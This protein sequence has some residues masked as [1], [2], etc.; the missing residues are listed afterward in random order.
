MGP[1]PTTMRKVRIFVAS[2][3]DVRDERDQLGR[4]VSELNQI[5]AALVPEA[6]LVLELVRW[7]THVHPGLGTDAQDVVNQQLDIGEYDVF[8][9]IFWLRFG[10]PTSRAESGTEEEFGIAYRAWKELG[11]A[12]QIMV[13][14]CRALAPPAEDSDAV[15]QLHKVV[16]FRKKLFDEGL[17]RDY[18]EHAEFADNVRRDLVLVLGQMLHATS[19]PAGI[20]DQA[21]QAVTDDDRGATRERIRA[22]AYEY[23]A[24]RDPK[25]GM[26][27]G[28][29]RTRRMEIV[30]SK[31]RA[32]ALSVYPFVDE[33][34]TSRSAGERLAAVST[35]EAVPD[36]RYLGWLAERFGP[37]KPFVA[38][39][40]ALGLLSAA[41]SLDR[42][43][44]PQVRA[45]LDEAQR[46]T[47]GLRE[48]T[49]RSTTLRYADHELV[50]RLT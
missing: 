11:R 6:G 18:G 36:A 23:D 28:S 41:R 46:A 17:A 50:R 42:D 7:E 37:E 9:G 38:Y 40:A 31:M 49:D 5:L 32:R 13:Y 8:V 22:L 16:K 39:H 44:L 4:V 26:P 48:D 47:R 1:T 20:A 3:G 45:A 27:S 12:I 43:E 15:M 29:E 33:L 25:T 14:F 19:S 21:G 10:T 30:A 24:I 2:P 34:I 35:L